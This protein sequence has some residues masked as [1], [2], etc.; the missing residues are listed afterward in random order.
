M[1]QQG[2]KLDFTGQHIYVGLDVSKTTWVISIHTEQF[3]HKTYSQEPNPE[4]L[5]K[6]LRRNFPGATYHVVYEAG[7]C[8]FWIHHA[9]TE[10]GVDC[11]VVNPADVP[12]K[13]KERVQKND[14]VDARKL[15]RDLKNGEIDPI[16]VPERISQEDRSLVRLRHQFVS[17]QTR[18]KNQIKALLG[19]YGVTIPNDLSRTHWSR[20]FIGWLEQVRF[21]R[22]SGTITLMTLL[23][24][25]KCLRRTIATVTKQIR[26][27]SLQ[28]PYRTNIDSLRTLDGISI[29]SGMIILTEIVDIHRFHST[30]QLAG[31]C[32][33]V[34]GE[35]SSG[36]RQIVTGISHRGN[37]LLRSLLI[38]CAWVA[39]RKDPSLIM[40]YNTL[41]K[42]MKP[43]RAII[44][45]ARKLLN[46]I[47]FVLN[48]Q[49]PYRPIMVG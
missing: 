23:E 48:H 3:E 49:Q 14:R 45:I 19:Y 31:Y 34:P 1:Q 43:N 20:K 4:L 27:F 38:E 26:A 12:T 10:R 24:E 29:L 37:T 47:Y 17:K 5:V 46:R 30:D 11:L 15:V 13:D 18:C 16:Y 22:E 42:R 41:T 36:D 2:T 28:E 25:L 39:V 9:L 6:Y 35:H 7:Y 44:R 21:Q 40:A 8:G 32:G 33:I